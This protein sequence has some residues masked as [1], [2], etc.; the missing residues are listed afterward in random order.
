MPGYER[1]VPECPASAYTVPGC[2]DTKY[3]ARTYCASQPSIVV[4]P[5]PYQ[6]A[7]GPAQ[8]PRQKIPNRPKL[9]E[10][11]PNQRLANP[12]FPKTRSPNLGFELRGFSRHRRRLSP[13]R[14]HAAK[15]AKPVYQ[16]NPIPT[17]SGDAIGLASGRPPPPGLPPSPNPNAPKLNYQT[18]P[19][20]K[21]QSRPTS[22]GHLPQTESRISPGPRQSKS[23]V[24]RA[25]KRP[26][27]FPGLPSY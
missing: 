2:P 23:T 13:K 17:A 24:A 8:P 19:I 3:A 16:T 4:P 5:R 11:L 25:S 18:D 20:P 9:A 14:P 15:F 22:Y 6:Q 1:P 26:A 10:S 21:N 12:G 27:A 7:S